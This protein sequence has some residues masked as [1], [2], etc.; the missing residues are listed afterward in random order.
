L[1]R[2]N[3]NATSYISQFL[4]GSWSPLTTN[5]GAV[6]IRPVVGKY[7]PHGSNTLKNSEISLTS[8]MQISPNPANDVLYMELLDGNPEDFRIECYDLA[9]R[10]VK[11]VLLQDNR[12]NVSDLASGMYVLRITDLKQNHIFNHK[13][14]I[15]R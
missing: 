1:D 13:F 5:W 3:L 15:N 2:N 11:T 10:C 9:G 7:W 14:V 8:V 12:M 4:S 6:M